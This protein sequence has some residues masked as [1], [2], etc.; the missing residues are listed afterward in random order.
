MLRKQW[1]LTGAALIAA[2]GI[3]FA[4]ARVTSPRPAEAEHTE[5]G[6]E[7]GEGMIKMTA[8]QA[9]AAGVTVVSVGRGG[10]GELALPGRV[11]FGPGAEA[12]V[13]A[14]LPGVVVQV[15]VAA[16]SPVRI[17]SPLAT[18]RSPE[19][20]AAR[21]T[22]DAEAA[23]ADAAR[24]VANRDKALFERGFVARQRVEI[25]EAEARRAEAELRAAR[26]RVQ[27]WGSPGS[28]GLVVVRSPVNGVVTSMITSPGSVLHEEALQV[29]VVADPS[30][31]EL[32]FEA[33]PTA[34]ATLRVGA[35]VQADAPDGT[36][37]E[38]VVTAIAPA[39]PGGTATVRARPVGATPPSGTILS[40]RIASAGAGAGTALTVPADAVQTV[41]G[42]P[43]VFVLTAAG[44]VARPV[45]TGRTSNGAVE[46]VSGLTGSERIAGAGAFLLKAELAKGE[47]E[48]G[49]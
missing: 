11:E 39:L 24:A 47:A 20:A 14:P 28:S 35:R 29:A 30:R 48:H 3:G 43:S 19:G 33:P 46:I 32:V 15:H 18:L 40:A 2:L 36:A 44:F 34:V 42:R 37:V 1:L 17:G 31:V 45:V 9:A 25:S 13:D 23:A 12:R 38:G 16:G 27:A 26:A 8:E 10:G 5:E 21:A 4:A 41:E 49:H 6:G 22:A 7:V